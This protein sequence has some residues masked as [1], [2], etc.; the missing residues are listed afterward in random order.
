[1]F[2]LITNITIGKRFPRIT[3]QFIIGCILYAIS[4][5]I[6]ANI[7][8]GDLFEQY[9]Y[10]IFALVIIDALFL[11]YLAKVSN[12]VNDKVKETN[13]KDDG[14]T[15]NNTTDTANVSHSNSLYSPTTISETNDIKVTHDISSSGSD[16]YEIFSTSESDKEVD[17]KEEKKS[18]PEETSLSVPSP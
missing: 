6:I 14:T 12:P 5:F 15:D 13:D 18:K 10:Y 8:K 16:K 4:F 11:V 2:F 3:T 7:M 9:K 1:M 17:V